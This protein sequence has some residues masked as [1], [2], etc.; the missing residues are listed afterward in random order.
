MTSRAENT[1]RRQRGRRTGDCPCCGRVTALTFH[2]LVPKKLHRRTRFRKHYTRAELAD[3][4][5][6]CRQ[7]HDGIHRF[8]DEMT[9]ARLY[10]TLTSLLED[11]DLARHFAWVGRQRRR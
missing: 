7:C 10:P 2:H 3:G 11:E 5:Y 9:L 4:I 1:T 8:H 6:I